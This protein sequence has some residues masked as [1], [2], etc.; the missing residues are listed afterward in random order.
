MPRRSHSPAPL[1]CDSQP[2]RWEWRAF[3]DDFGEAEQRIRFHPRRVLEEGRIGYLLSRHAGDRI[4]ADERRLLVEEP[5][6]IGLPPEARSPAGDESLVAWRTVLLHPFPIGRE[7]MRELARTLGHE[8]KP[9]QPPSSVAGPGS[10]MA[11]FSGHP[12]LAVVETAF[13]RGFY[14]V[15]DCVV[16]LGELSFGDRRLRTVAVAMERRDRILEAVKGLALGRFESSSHVAMFKRH[17]ALDSD[18]T[19]PRRRISWSLFAD[20]SF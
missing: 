7:T 1:S 17:L 2:L 19:R 13:R 12:D 4:T 16:E 6:C 15:N 11:A 5:S 3:G 18:T 9:A 10:L 8:A 14:L 20:C